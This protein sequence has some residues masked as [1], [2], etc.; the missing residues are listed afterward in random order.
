MRTKRDRATRAKKK[1]SFGTALYRTNAR[2]LLAD[3]TKLLRL[4][5]ISANFEISAIE[6]STV[7]NRTKGHRIAYAFAIGE[8]LSYWH[9]DPRYLDQ[10]GR[11]IALKMSGKGAS[12]RQLADRATPKTSAKEVLDALLRARAVEILPNGTIR[13]IRRTLTV[14]SDRD[15]AIHHTFIVLKGILRTL[16]HNLQSKPQNADQLF[17]RIAWSSNQTASDIARLRVWLNKHGQGFLESADDWMKLKEKT[18]EKPMRQY[19]VSIGTYLSID[20]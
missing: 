16:H 7:S 4:L 10:L 20:Q 8:I 17:H 14:F 3:L 11:P 15:M 1:T 2:K 12:F 5:G 9:Q 13:P 19:R 6:G 18:K